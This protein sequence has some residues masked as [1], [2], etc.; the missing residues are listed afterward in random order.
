[1]TRLKAYVTG[2]KWRER[3]EE[4]NIVDVAFDSHQENAKI[5]ETRE[6][7][8]SACIMLDRWRVVVP[9]ADGGTY[10]GSGFKVEERSLAKFVVACEGPF[11]FLGD[12]A[13]SVTGGR[14][15]RRP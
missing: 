9:S 1:M 3:P 4:E 10:V 2:S 15:S 7:A 11:I 14:S 13:E 8:E 6:E 5:F 12:G